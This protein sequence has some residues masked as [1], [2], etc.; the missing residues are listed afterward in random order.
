[1][2]F[3]Q[4]RRPILLSI[5]AALLTLGIK[6]AAYKWTDSVG[7]FSDA[8]ESLANLLASTTALACL[9]YASQ[10]VDESHTYGHE[11]IEYFSSGLEGMLILSAA[12]GIAWYAIKRLFFPEPI[13]EL[14]LGAALSLGAALVNLVV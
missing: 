13:Y 11:K 5:A 8:M 4:L 14:R 10:P 7:L 3:R 2:D 1:M 6:F 9:W 12:A